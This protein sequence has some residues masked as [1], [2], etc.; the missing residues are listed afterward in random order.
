MGRQLAL[1][2]IK[3]SVNKVVNKVKVVEAKL[4]YLCTWFRFNFFKKR[5]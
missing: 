1:S 4:A 2:G 5:K 3:V